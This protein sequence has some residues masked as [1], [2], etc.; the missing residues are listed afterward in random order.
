MS[1]VG[2]NAY[3]LLTQTAPTGLRWGP[4]R[5]SSGYVAAGVFLTS[6]LI[7][8]MPARTGA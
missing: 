3:C 8:A 5:Q 2:V 1:R 7:R 6:A 4:S